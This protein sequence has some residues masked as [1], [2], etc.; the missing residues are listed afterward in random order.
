MRKHKIYQDDRINIKVKPFT[1]SKLSNLI[2]EWTIEAYLKI[3]DDTNFKR[4]TLNESILKLIEE[5]EKKNN[6]KD[7]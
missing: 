7:G 4:M 1:F 2:D 5:F 6:K 3:D